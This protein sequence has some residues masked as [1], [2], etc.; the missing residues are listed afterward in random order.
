MS[1]KCLDAFQ[2]CLKPLPL[3]MP[4]PL[5]LAPPFRAQ[6]RRCGVRGSRFRDLWYLVQGFGFR[7]SVSGFRL[8]SAGFRFRVHVQGFKFKFRVPEPV[9]EGESDSAR[10][11]AT[12]QREEAV[13]PTIRNTTSTTPAPCLFVLVSGPNS[14]DNPP[15]LS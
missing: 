11:H 12:F 7:V 8:W 5:V 10:A 1:L 2:H 4:E 3:Q 15:V 6:G 9:V 14:D 13:P